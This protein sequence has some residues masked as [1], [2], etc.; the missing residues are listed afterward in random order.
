M[1][2]YATTVLKCVI[3]F[4][5]SS[6]SFSAR[7]RSAPH[8]LEDGADSRAIIRGIPTPSTTVPGPCLGHWSPVTGPQSYP[9]SGGLEMKFRDQT[10]ELAVAAIT[11]VSETPAS[12]E[13]DT[14]HH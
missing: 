10:T 12:M 9:E 5:L 11:N 3:F 7:G 4:I 8:K 1:L 14:V 6:C 13:Q 2:T